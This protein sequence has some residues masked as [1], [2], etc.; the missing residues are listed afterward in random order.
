MRWKNFKRASWEN[1]E[2][3]VEDATPIVEQYLLSQR[4]LHRKERS[5]VKP[6]QITVL[7]KV[8]C[9]DAEKDKDVAAD[10]KSVKIPFDPK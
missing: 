9:S 6:N 7:R 10:K 8:K 5:P 4:L 3:F 2:Q 1:F